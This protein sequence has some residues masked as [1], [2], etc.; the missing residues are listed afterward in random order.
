MRKIITVTVIT[1]CLMITGC[2]HYG[3]PVLLARWFD[4]QDPCQRTPVPDYCGG[5][6]TDRGQI[7]D[8][9]G[10]VIASQYTYAR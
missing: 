2:G 5:Y 7:T 1:C 6:V 4:A 3:E 9:T 8:P 10:R